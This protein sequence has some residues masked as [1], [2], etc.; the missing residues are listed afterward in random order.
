VTRI[1]GRIESQGRKV[2]AE[3]PDKV[4]SKERQAV[5]ANE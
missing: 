5:V 3:S 1:V 4:S 2:F